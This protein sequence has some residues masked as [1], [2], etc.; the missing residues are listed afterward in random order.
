[1]DPFDSV[2][3]FHND[4]DGSRRISREQR[5]SHQ[6]HRGRY[7]EVKA[8]IPGKFDMVPFEFDGLENQLY[9]IVRNHEGVSLSIVSK[10]YW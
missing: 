8:N 7:G 3:V 10:D 9:S 1:M 6:W 5:H 2:Q 4:Q